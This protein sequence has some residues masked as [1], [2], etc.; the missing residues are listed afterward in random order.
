MTDSP[1]PSSTSLRRSAPDPPGQGSHPP[2]RRQAPGPDS[3][4]AASCERSAAAPS[5]IAVMSDLAR[6]G[7]DPQAAARAPSA[8][9]DRRRHPAPATSIASVSTWVWPVGSLAPLAASEAGQNGHIL[10]SLLARTASP[11]SSTRPSPASSRSISPRPRGAVVAPFRPITTMN[12]RTRVSRL[13]GPTRA[14]SCSPTPS[15]QPA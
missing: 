11:I 2:H 13:T 1:T 9:P 15:A 7:R 10:A 5:W 12:S 6:S 14:P 8:H 3:P 4:M